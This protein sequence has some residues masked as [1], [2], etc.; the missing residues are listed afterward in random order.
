MKIEVSIGELVDKVSILSI[1]LK[2]VKNQDKLKNIQKEFDLL[3][4]P[5]EECGIK[6]D[7]EYFRRLQEVNS[8]LWVIE[9]GIRIKEVNQEF[10]QDF[11]QLARSVYF[12]N[13]ERAAIKKEINLKFGSEL[14]EEKEYVEYKDKPAK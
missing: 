10:D 12:E 4:V 5:M 1:K 11:I 13:D 6:I 14:V 9:D 7:S 8:R 3:K 2:K